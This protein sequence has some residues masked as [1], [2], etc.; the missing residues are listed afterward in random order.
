MIFDSPDRPPH[1]PDRGFFV[2]GSKPLVSGPQHF[3]YLE[4]L[5]SAHVAV[6]D[7]CAEQVGAHAQ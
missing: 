6:T 2:C 1:P 3:P 5:C 7:G 4:L